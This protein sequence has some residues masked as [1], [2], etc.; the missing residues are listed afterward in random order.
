MIVCVSFLIC[1]GCYKAQQNISTQEATNAQYVGKETCRPCHENIYAQYTGSDHDL[2]MDFATDATALGDFNNASFNHLGI[3]SKFYKRDGRYFVFTEGEGGAFQEFAIAYTFGVRPLQQYLVEFPKGRLQTL[4][5][6]WD[7]RPKEQGGQRWFHIYGNER[8]PPDDML[9]WTKISQ[10]WNYMCAECHSTNLKKNYDV[11]S[12]RYNTTWSEIDV[13]C[14]ACHGP[15]SQHVEW[16]EAEE[17]GKDTQG[18][19]D[20]GLSIRLKNDEDEEVTWI[21]DKKLATYKPST[22]RRRQKEVEMCARCHSRRGVISEDYVHGKPLLDTHYPHVL[23]ENLYYPDGQIRDEVY[24]Y[25]SFLQSKMYQSGIVCTDCHDP[26]TTRRRKEGNELC[27]SCHQ[28]EKYGS[29]E[30]HFHKLDSAGSQ[31][32]ECHMPSR[33]YMVVDP[34]R[35][36]SFRVPRPDLS[37]KL[38]VPNACNDCHADKSTAWAAEHFAKWYGQPKSGMHYGEI[39]R[40]AS[41]CTPGTDADL[42][43]LVED[44]QQSSMV[45]AT[46]ILQ[47]RNYPNESSLKTL[48]KMLQD[49]NPLIRSVAVA[50]LDVLPPKDRVHFLLP[51]L[52]DSVRLV[53]TLAARSIA[54]VP[55]DVLSNEAWQQSEVAI[56]EYEETQL[57]N[58]D[59]PATLINLGNLYLERGEFGRAAATYKKAIEIEPAF[60]PG[61][62]NLADVCRLQNRDEEGRVI[63]QNALEIAP[64]SAPAHHALGLLMIRVGEH[65]SALRHLRKAALLAPENVQYSYV[66]GIAL[67]SLEMSAQAISVLKRALN[68]NP[69]DRDLLVS[70][71]AIHR[72]RGEFEKALRYAVRLGKNYPDNKN[73]QQLEQQ[74]R[75]LAVRQG[76]KPGG[77]N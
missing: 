26:H 19:T 73:Y 75:A 11:A 22:P 6:C 21:F 59:Y 29:H 70:L 34:R 45:R 4:P 23:E 18:Y 42:V 57:L 72:D 60:V 76:D 74:L 36:H 41:R 31:C 35:D 64:E 51:V 10:N 44:N 68:R 48:G 58:A 55:S 12:G 62:I 8:I 46:A 65:K 1:I 2:A 66:Y 27:Y 16:A 52:Q 7:T 24:E 14:E 37:K 3:T 40:D 63:L 30:H 39:F 17:N 54:A 71:A 5:L 15:C 28:A 38:G 13:S 69:Y 61:Y 20:M 56:K 53:R 33:T 9:Y 32:V 47:L 67:N 49:P 43:H 25:G 50:S 77:Q